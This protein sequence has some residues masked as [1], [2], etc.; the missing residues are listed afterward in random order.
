MFLALAASVAQTPLPRQWAQFGRSGLL[1][2]V[3]ETVD[4]ATGDTKGEPNLPYTLR[5]TRTSPGAAPEVSW[6]KSSTC[7]AVRA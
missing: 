7:P 4:I 2:G 1:S 5:F 6:A 3:T